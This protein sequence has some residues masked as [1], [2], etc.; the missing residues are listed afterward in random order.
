M[1]ARRV[2]WAD[3]AKAEGRKAARERQT[4]RSNPYF[5]GSV[6]WMVWRRAFLRAKRDAR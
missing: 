6:R 1:T 3:R 4:E 5:V 2:C